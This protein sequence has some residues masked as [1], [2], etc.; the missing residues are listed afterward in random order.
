MSRLL[1]NTKLC[2][3]HNGAVEIKDIKFYIFL[4][5]KRIY[6]EKLL[7]DKN[8]LMFAVKML[9]VVIAQRMS[10][11][12]AG[13]NIFGKG[14]NKTDMYEVS[15]VAFKSPLLLLYSSIYTNVPR[16]YFQKLLDFIKY[17]ML[18]FFGINFNFDVY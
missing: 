1:L 6:S 3:F 4:S 9:K 5:K 7:V 10:V 12:Y 11:R 13:W 18:S 17:Q 2:V 16:F 15:A 14:S 8:A